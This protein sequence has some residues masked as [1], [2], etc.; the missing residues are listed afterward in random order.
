MSQPR[1]IHIHP[2]APAK[3]APGASCNGCGVCCS[4]ELCPLAIIRYLRVAGP[5]PA[6]QWQDENNRYM[7]G[8]LANASQPLM[9]R[10]LRR[11]IAA[12]DGCDCTIEVE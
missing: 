7:C 4:A 2:D 1:I 8:M 10:W 9:Q 12:G 11:M 5:C 3:P 6:L